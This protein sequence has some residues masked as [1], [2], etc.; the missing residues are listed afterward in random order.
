MNKQAVFCLLLLLLFISA[1]A[2]E[3]WDLKRVV[4][5]ALANNIS[6]RQQDV[7]ARLTAL[8]YNQS[9]LSQYPGVNFSTSVGLS[10]GRSIDRTTNQF[11]T[12]SVFYNGFNLQASA[13]IFNFGSKKNAIAAYRYQSQASD[14]SVDK[15]KNDIALNTAGAYLQV[16]L[17]REQAEISRVQVQQTLA[18]LNNTRKLVQA[19]SLPEFN[20]AELESQL[21]MD[22]SNLI[23]AKGSEAQALLTLKA[24]LSLD[25]ATPFDVVTPP[26]E[27]IPIEPLSELQPEAVYSLAL[28]NLPQ[29]RVN[30]LSL[31]AAQ[32]NA[33]AAHGLMYPAI[34]IGGS[35]QTNYSNAKNQTE[36]LG[37][38]PNGFTK[39]GVVSGTLD[40]VVAP[41]LV[42]NYRFYAAPYGNQF[43]NNFGNSI[44][45][46]IS[47]PIFNGGSARTS[48]QKAKL[49]I[50]SY[51]LQQQQDN[52]NLKTDIYKAYTDAVT[53][54][55]K[56]HASSKAV[57]T[58]QIAFD[59]ATKRYNVGLLNTIELINTQT[60]L[61]TA[62]LQKTLAQYD[63]VFKVKVLEFYKGQGLKL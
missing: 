54:I 2:Q 55:E 49:N 1:S 40:T 19:G 62:K 59:F 37:F 60:N 13:D 31:K 38:T 43:T 5:Y 17:A 46:S 9:K 14:A 61:F 26:I 7:Q 21:A 58:A 28:V 34:S 39:I 52:L 48:W 33:D 3:K 25:A 63:Y 16:L 56:F 20:A 57:E 42:P 35:L 29:Q 12:Q 41:N 50:K 23:S 11:T 44:G 6:V 15:L 10:T 4:E 27:M 51:E 36:L 24:L 32:K 18:Q 22:S 8:T 47:V 45:I 53:A 30:D